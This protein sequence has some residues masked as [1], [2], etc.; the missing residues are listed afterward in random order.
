VLNLKTS[1]DLAI[2][3]PPAVLSLA[4]EVIQ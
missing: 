2:L 4:D 1:K 3:I